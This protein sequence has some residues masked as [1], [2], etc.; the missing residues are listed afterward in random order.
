MFKEAAAIK[1][2]SSILG[3]WEKMQKKLE[4]AIESLKEV[5][6]ENNQKKIEIQTRANS[7]INNL[8]HKNRILTK[9]MNKAMNAK[10]N[11]SKMLS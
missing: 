5:I 7:E 4:K 3:A 8:D 10:D 11:I 1:T 9:E 6:S 2:I